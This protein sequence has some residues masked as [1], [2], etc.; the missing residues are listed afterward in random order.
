VLSCVLR[1]GHGGSIG[2]APWPGKAEARGLGAPPGRL[3]TE[4]KTPAWT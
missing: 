2:R 3:A 4:T 1:L